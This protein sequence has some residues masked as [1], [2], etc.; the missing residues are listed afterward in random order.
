MRSI[1]RPPTPSISKFSPYYRPDPNS[2]R[3]IVLNKTQQSV[4]NFEGTSTSTH[5]HPIRRKQESTLTSPSQLK[6]CANKIYRK[7]SATQS[8]N[9]SYTRKWDQW[10]PAKWPSSEGI[11]VIKCSHSWSTRVPSLPTSVASVFA[12]NGLRRV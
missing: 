6:P 8:T 12:T 4:S 1:L 11:G 3:L 5:T 10:C 9:T 7:S 2:F